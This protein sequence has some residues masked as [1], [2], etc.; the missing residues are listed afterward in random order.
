MIYLLSFLHKSLHKLIKSKEE[1]KKTIF[2]G[3]Q[4]NPGGNANTDCKEKIEI[5]S[6]RWSWIHN[7]W[8]WWNFDG[9][10][11]YSKI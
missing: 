1:K 7:I 8:E 2:N 10:H 5:L 11:I 9:L 3:K 4:R 6:H